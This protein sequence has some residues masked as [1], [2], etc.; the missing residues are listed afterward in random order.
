MG[1]R[2][3]TPI[4][5]GTAGSGGVEKMVRVLATGV[6]DILHLGHLHFFEEARKLGDELV[7]VVA[8]DRRVRELKHEPI[9]PEDVR[10]EMVGAMRPVDRAILG[11]EGDIFDIVEELRP[12]VIALGYDQP[13]D[14]D[15]ISA[16]IK[17]RGLDVKVV[18]LPKM[19]LDLD[20]T[21]KIIRRII[22]GYTF[23]KRMEALE[24]R[25]ATKAKKKDA[26]REQSTLEG[27]TW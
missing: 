8:T 11:K 1:S 13:H 15:E 24:R 10:V 2:A 27:K 6:F 17:K 19:D 12:D 3:W 23:Q 21:R 20:A 18:R 16:A 4:P 14:P 26:G 5:R 9:M 25:A 7:V 22:D